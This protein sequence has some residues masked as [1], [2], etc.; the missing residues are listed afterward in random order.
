MAKVTTGRACPSWWLVV[1][2]LNAKHPK[3]VYRFLAD[4]VGTWRVR[5]NPGVEQRLF[6]SAVPAAG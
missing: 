4:E 5:F 1:N 6:M 3:A 2:R